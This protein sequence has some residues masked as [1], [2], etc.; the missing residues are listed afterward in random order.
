MIAGKSEPICGSD[1]GKVGLGIV[2][3]SI[4]RAFQGRLQEA[5]VPEPE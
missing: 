1:R 5:S 2:E 3:E 4:A